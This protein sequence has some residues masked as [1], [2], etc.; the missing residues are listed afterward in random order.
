[1]VN[2]MTMTVGTKTEEILSASAW[3]G[4]RDPSASFTIDIILTSSVSELTFVA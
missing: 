3:I 1:M 4:A 2:A